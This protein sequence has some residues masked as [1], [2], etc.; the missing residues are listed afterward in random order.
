[1][2]LHT[3]EQIDNIFKTCVGLYNICYM[4]GTIATSGSVELSGAKEMEILQTVESIGGCLCTV[5]GEPVFA[6]ADYSRFGRIMFNGQVIL[7]L[8][9]QRELLSA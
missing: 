5:N 8:F 3:K 4:T 7:M 1:M 9:L 2:R 6:E